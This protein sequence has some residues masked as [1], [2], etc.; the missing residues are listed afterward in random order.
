VTDREYMTCQDAALLLKE[1]PLPSPRRMALF[2]C[3][4]LRAHGALAHD[5]MTRD[6]EALV[7]VTEG[8]HRGRLSRPQVW[9]AMRTAFGIFPIGGTPPDA[10]AAIVAAHLILELYPK[11]EAVEPAVK[12]LTTFVRV[13]AG[14]LTGIPSDSYAKL[15]RCVGGLPGA[16]RVGRPPR[17]A[18]ALARE[19]QASGDWTLLPILADALDEN[20][21]GPE[22]LAHLRSTPHALGC[23]VV[24]LV[25]ARPL[26]GH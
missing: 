19:V 26:G 11:A 14:G 16:G 6:V 22:A 20:G 17:E 21:A 9:A 13:S 4:A 15:Y 1:R 3:A 23:C 8:Y 25:A 24:D 5:G 10:E 12:F 18:V 7:K 2:L